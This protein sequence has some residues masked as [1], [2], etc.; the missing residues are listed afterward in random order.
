MSVCSVQ[1]WASVCGPISPATPSRGI[2]RKGRGA[3]AGMLNST[4]VHL[5]T[6]L[7]IQPWRLLHWVC[8]SFLCT[9]VLLHGLNMCLCTAHTRCT[10]AHIW[11]DYL[12]GNPTLKI[13]RQIGRH[14][15][16][17]KIWTHCSY[18]PSQP[19]ICLFLCA[20]NTLFDIRSFPPQLDLLI[21]NKII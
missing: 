13:T 18:F 8:V 2:A 12:P 9:C 11:S 10:V 19:Q 7:A 15:P 6:Y 1:C 4:T 14:F 16:G 17:P 3:F 20:S 21:K 5:I